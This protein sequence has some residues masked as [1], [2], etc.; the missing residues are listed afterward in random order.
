[1]RKIPVQLMKE[2]VSNYF[3]Y[4]GTWYIVASDDITI[5][6]DINNDGSV[7]SLVNVSKLNR[8]QIS[9]SSGFARVYSDKP[10]YLYNSYTVV[11]PSET[12]F[13]IP[14]SEVEKLV[15]TEDNTTVKADITNDG[16]Y[17][18][19]QMYNKDVY[20]NINFDEGTRIHSDKPIVVF[21]SSWHNIPFYVP[22]SNMVGSDLWS[23][24]S[25]TY[26]YISG[27]YDNTTY[28]LDRVLD[29]DLNPDYTYTI[30]YG[31]T[32]SLPSSGKVHIWG[33]KPFIETYRDPY[34]D[35]SCYE[36]YGY[37]YSIYPY[38]SISSTTY[39]LHKYLGANEITPIKAGI[40]NP[41][42]NTSIYNVSITVPFPDSFSMPLGT[43]IELNAKKRYLRNDTMIENEIITLTP[44]HIAGNYVFTVSN[45]DS[46]LFNSLDSMQYYDMEYQLITP[47]ITGEYKFDSVS[48]EYTAKTWNLPEVSN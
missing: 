25:G 26:A 14:W 2:V 12:D 43:S 11:G 17:D 4:A 32:K 1:M 33:D 35:G 23:K 15:I 44:S 19:S 10:F 36:Y 8:G 9:V 48:V 45:N 29:N 3:V 41:F 31:E 42:A 27:M 22:P 18:W 38:S 34:H 5:N 46:Q 24:S 40:F 39:N 13:N 6:V 47:S 21:T 7:D 28:Y 20:V 30:D 16:I 37:Y